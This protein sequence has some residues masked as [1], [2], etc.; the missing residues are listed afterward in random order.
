MTRF[1]PHRPKRML[2]IQRTCLVQDRPLLYCPLWP[3]RSVRIV[4]C[5]SAGIST[6]CTLHLHNHL[7]P[8]RSSLALPRAELPHLMPFS[9][10]NSKFPETQIS[11]YVHFLQFCMHIFPTN[12]HYLLITFHQIFNVFPFRFHSFTKNVIVNMMCNTVSNIC[13][14]ICVTR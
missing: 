14:S 8:L 6:S 10:S 4:N 7:L 3:S 11:V 13:I 5:L 9:Y 12:I 1:C 2:P